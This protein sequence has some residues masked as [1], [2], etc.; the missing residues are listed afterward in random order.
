MDWFNWERERESRGMSQERSERR[1]REKREEGGGGGAEQE[2]ESRCEAQLTASQSCCWIF[3]FSSLN[4]LVWIFKENVRAP[5]AEVQ[6][7]CQRRASCRRGADKGRTHTQ[8]KVVI[9]CNNSQ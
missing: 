5:Q 9:I 6:P 7:V 4:L 8:R 3:C 1:Q 2:S